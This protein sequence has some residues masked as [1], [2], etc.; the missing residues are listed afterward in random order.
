MRT[1][2]KNG[3]QVARGRA[4]R[5]EQRQAGRAMAQQPLGAGLVVVRREWEQ[6]FLAQHAAGLEAAMHYMVAMV[7]DPRTTVLLS[8][9][10]APAPPPASAADS[11]SRSRAG[12]TPVMSHREQRRLDALE[13]KRPR[14]AVAARAL[15]TNRTMRKGKRSGFA[16]LARQQHV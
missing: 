13:P 6:Q 16:R 8:D 3:A 9:S 7:G 10:T 11:A 4:A 12:G 15:G 2:V 5:A 1:E 14:A